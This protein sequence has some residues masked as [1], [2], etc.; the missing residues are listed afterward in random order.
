MKYWIMNYEV[1]IILHCRKSY[2]KHIITILRTQKI[3]DILKY[4]HYPCFRIH[5]EVGLEMF[6][7]ETA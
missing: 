7:K 4:H 2:Y 1:S 6:V 3:M 5:F